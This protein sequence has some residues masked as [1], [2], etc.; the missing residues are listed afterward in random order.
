[1]TTRVPAISEAAPARER[2]WW[3]LATLI[4]CT[5][6][7]LSVFLV[8]MEISAAAYKALAVTVWMILLWIFAPIDHAITGLAGCVL[9]WVTGAVNFETAFSGYSRDTPWFLFGAIIFGSVAAQ[10]GLARRLAYSV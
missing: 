4:L 5:A 2:D 6:V 3:K 10:T 1:M 8:P 7:S 9:Y